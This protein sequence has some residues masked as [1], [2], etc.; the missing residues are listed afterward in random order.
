MCFLTWTRTRRPVASPSTAHNKG[1]DS[2][3]WQC[4]TLCDR[5][6]LVTAYPRSEL[7][8]GTNRRSS[9]SRRR[10]GTCH[11]RG[12]T[13]LPTGSCIYRDRLAYGLSYLIVP[14]NLGRRSLARSHR[15]NCSEAFANHAP[16]HHHRSRLL[17]VGFS[18][19]S[20]PS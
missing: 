13:R 14:R 3:L 4:P 15:P 19:S 20:G 7:V 12:S 18:R 8:H 6:P 17:H 10:C 5:L 1:Q 9:V 2:G 11:R 16:L